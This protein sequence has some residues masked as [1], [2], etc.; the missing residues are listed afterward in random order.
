MFGTSRL[1]SILGAAPEATA[2]VDVMKRYVRAA[3]KAELALL[4]VQPGTKIPADLRTA[5]AKKKDQAAHE[6]AGGTGTAPAGLH[7]ATA[8][9]ATLAKYATAYRKTYGDDA[10][11]N[12]ALHPGRSR[13]LVV[14]ADTPEEVSAWL[15]WWSEATG[16][17]MTG[18]AP[19]VVTPG[20]QGEDGSWKHHG[21]GH[22]YLSL[23]EDY[24]HPTGAPS[25]LKMTHDGG[26][27]TVYIGDCYVLIPPSVRAEGSY[28]VVGTDN[29]APMALLMAISEAAKPRTSPSKTRPTKSTAATAPTDEA[30]EAAQRAA[31]AKGREYAEREGLTEPEPIGTLTEWSEATDWSEILVPAGFTEA[32][33][34]RQC[35]CP[36]W[37]APGTH[38]SRKSAT[39]HECGDHDE[40]G[41]LHI[42]TDNP[43]T[44]TAMD[45]EVA[46][47]RR[48]FSKL[49]TQ[50]LLTHGGDIRATMDAERIDR[51][52]AE[53]HGRELS[54]RKGSRQTT[55]ETL[56]PDDWDDEAETLDP[57]LRAVPIGELWDQPRPEFIVAETL[58]ADG[59]TAII[60]ASGVG[61]SFVAL[62]L[63][64]SIVT[65]R[66]WKGHEVRQGRVLY[67]AGEGVYG[68][69]DR[70]R[71]WAEEYNEA[72]KIKAGLIVISEGVALHDWGGNKWQEFRDIIRDH[73]VD[74]VILDTWARVTAGMEE[75]SSK[76]VGHV[77]KHLDRLKERTG[78]GMCVV[79]HTTRGTTHGRGS[80]ALLGA[81]D[82]EL[83]VTESTTGAATGKA[84][85]VMT[86]K[87]KNGREWEHPL[88]FSIATRGDSAIVAD[89]DGRTDADQNDTDHFIHPGASVPTLMDVALQ[90]H[91]L[92]IRRGSI[93]ATEGKLA[94]ISQRPEGFDA[95]GWRELIGYA[96]AD[97][98]DFGLV[99]R[100][101]D[102]TLYVPS[103]R[104]GIRAAYRADRMERGGAGV[105]QVEDEEE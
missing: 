26:E 34:D 98:L 61:K 97:G 68:A 6:E 95:N 82:S 45:D 67:V 96:M 60:G 87:Q 89:I 38:D 11:I 72:E 70:V 94:S 39:T 41:R 4:Y 10:A 8:D 77:I 71:T 101:T 55:A 93:G 29:P 90:M 5:A 1:M 32:G 74:L 43:S 12:L 79:H 69:V 85:D 47:G 51:S 63:A 21:G 57:K 105:F 100:P 52:T 24:S 50:A 17:D 36:V 44:G 46:D 62:D 27:F 102:G 56:S 80:T 19:T 103:E 37:T 33:T 104:R 49:Q 76:E 83:L 42:W 92:L 78:T 16:H 13:V 35:G 22:W 99:L 91:A 25:K 59:L 88:T 84:I 15:G 58:Q 48:D 14:D 31:E 53:S 20:A 7:L 54:P 9:P 66:M 23:P 28:E 18:V 2:P 75:N 65:G 81:L 86:T 64:C 30:W 3:G 40:G 73:D